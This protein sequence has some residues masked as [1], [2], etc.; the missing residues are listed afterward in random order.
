[1]LH[2][3]LG[4]YAEQETT[5]YFTRGMFHFH[6]IVETTQLQVDLPLIADDVCFSTRNGPM[7][8]PGMFC[9][10]YLEGGKDACQ[11]DSGIG[12]IKVFEISQLFD[13]NQFASIEKWE[14]LEIR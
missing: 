10:G 11:G 5:R 4:T 7:L 14:V 9:A 3:W 2:C 13:C 12:F 8:K 6:L 1:M